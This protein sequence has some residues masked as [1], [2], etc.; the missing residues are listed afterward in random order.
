M[1]TERKIKWLFAVN[2]LINWALSIRGIIDPA[3]AAAAFGF[4]NPPAEFSF[5]LR[6]WAS[7]VFMFGCMFWETSRDVRG[8]AALIK[9]N[10][11]EKSLTALAVTLGFLAG[12]T[13][14][15]LMLTITLTNWAWI[16][17][18]IY[19]DLRLRGEMGTVHPQVA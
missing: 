1:T 13:P 16:P 4:A 11:I 19:Y 2:A 5:V 12:Q 7:F 9:Y 17:F 15:R 14:D 8:K 3:G 10:W 6:L 18:L